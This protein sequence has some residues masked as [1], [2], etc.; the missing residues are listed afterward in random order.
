MRWLNIHVDGAFDA[1]PI[2]DD[3]PW[4]AN[5]PQD[6]T[7]TDNFDLIFNGNIS[8]NAT[9]D[10]NV[11]GIDIGFDQAALANENGGVDHDAAFDIAFDHELLTTKD[12]ALNSDCLS[13]DG[14][15]TTWWLL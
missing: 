10:I 5:I 15:G 8:D 11:V 12:F 14:M 1:G 4:G 2:V 6:V 9:R 7:T 13:D 3:Q